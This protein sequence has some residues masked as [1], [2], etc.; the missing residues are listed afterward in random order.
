MPPI[1]ARMR[2]IEIKQPGGPEALVLAERAVPEVRP[3]EVL[4]AVRAAGI[5]RPDV[6]QRQGGYPPPPGASDIPGLEIAGTVV[7]CGDGVSTPA[8]GDHVCALIAGGGYAEYA[9]APADRK[10]VV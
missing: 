6:L 4:I 9:T 3:G 8:I 2:C 1:P 7:A 10:S 5:N